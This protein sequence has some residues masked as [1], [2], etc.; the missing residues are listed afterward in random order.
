MINEEVAGRFRALERVMLLDSLIRMQENATRLREI[1]AVLG[2]YGLADW[3]ARARIRWLRKYLVTPQGQQLDQLRTEERVRLALLELGTTFIK[4]GQML[5]TRP[6]LVGPSLAA[7]LSQLQDSTPADPPEVV[8]KTIEA[9]LGQPAER[10][11]EEFCYEPIASASIGQV[12]AARLPGGPAVVVKV[13]HQGIEQRVRRDL[14]L[15]HGLAEL[16]QRYL[17][18]L[19]Y[20]QPIATVREF[21]RT[22]LRELDL[23]RER[24]NLEEFARRFAGDGSV[25]FPLVYPER[26]S[27]CVLTMERL[28]GVPGTQATKAHNVDLAAF[29]RR[30]GM[31]YLNMIFRDGFFHADP[32][33]GNYVILPGGVI[34]V[35]DC[36]MVGR[37]DDGLREE[38]EA[39]V[40]AVADGDAE[41]L[42]ERVVRLG[43]APPDLDRQAL[44]ADVTDFVVEYGTRPLGELNLGSALGEMVDIIARYH[45]LLPA[46]ASLLLRTLLVL[47]GTARQLDPTFSLIELIAEHKAGSGGWLPGARRWFREMRRTG[48]DLDRLVRLLP[49]D[50]ADVLHRLRT[51]TFEIKHEHHRLEASVN[52]LVLG[53]LTASLLLS[54]AL[55]L[56]GGGDDG[57]PCFIR[58]ALGLICLGLGGF[59][60][61]RVVRSINSTETNDHAG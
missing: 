11:F 47:D 9:D 19:R 22:L 35:L 52:R 3:L 41:G 25:H 58:P 7:E 6:D 10:L 21:R 50:L 16:A 23:T 61:V 15:L 57:L 56:R 53:L 12:L 17:P 49:G 5:S 45:I 2:K 32:H 59:L 24:R 26:C 30:A 4:L 40:L 31:M 37:L 20:Y 43:S 13:Q 33:P 48:R 51:G 36:G 29:A 54:S 14:N 27:R 18:G 60:G 46:Q 38:I 28:E 55:L 34:G 44:H 39:L 42:V 1:L 8:R